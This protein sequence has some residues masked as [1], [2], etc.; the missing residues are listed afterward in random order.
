MTKH[1]RP[2]MILALFLALASCS[3]QPQAAISSCAPAYESLDA[4]LTSC[5]LDCELAS[6]DSDFSIVFD[7]TAN[8]PPYDCQDGQDPSGIANPRL[9][10]YQSLRA[11]AA[12]RFDQ[13]LPW[14]ELPLYEW[15]R[16]T[17][18][19]FVITAGESSSCCDDQGRMVLSLES[20]SLPLPA[21]WDSPH[22]GI[23]LSDLV[24]PIIHE[25]RHT[26]VG[27]HTCGDDDLTLDELGAWGTQYHFY[28]WSA[29]HAAPGML[30]DLEIQCAMAHAQMNL[31]HFCD[32]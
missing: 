31:I 9:V 3:L 6:I 10:V 2:L 1:G 28:I 13:P 25:A 15:L 26:E 7:E 12:L 18:N 27:Q 17:I 30:S 8:L 21:R 5:P 14:T 32:P 23:A 19:G 29:E 11:V 4:V 22:R 24:A 16:S 20:L